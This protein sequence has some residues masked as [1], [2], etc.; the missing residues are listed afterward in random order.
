MARM[1]ELEGRVIVIAIEGYGVLI[2]VV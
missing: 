2:V 1:K